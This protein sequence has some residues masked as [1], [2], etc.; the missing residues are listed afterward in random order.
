MSFTFSEMLSQTSIC[1][2]TLARDNKR[3]FKR[4]LCRYLLGIA[5]NRHAIEALKYLVSKYA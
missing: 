1:L 2:L 3:L 5:C 4:S